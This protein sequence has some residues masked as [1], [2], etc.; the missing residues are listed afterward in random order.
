MIEIAF[1]LSHKNCLTLRFI[2][3]MT[4]AFHVK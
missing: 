1:R 2:Q 4:K 3:D